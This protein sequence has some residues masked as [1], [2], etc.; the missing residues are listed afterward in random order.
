MGICG[1]GR[2]KE[3]D[4]VWHRGSFSGHNSFS[5][6]DNLDKNAGDDDVLDASKMAEMQNQVRTQRK[7]LTVQ[8]NLVGLPKVQSPEEMAAALKQLEAEPQ[9]A[10][11]N[12][13]GFQDCHY[14]ALSKK[15]YVPY[16]DKVNQDSL[17]C[18]ERVTHNVKGLDMHFFG[19]LDG[20]GHHGRDVSQFVTAE[21]PG[22]LEREL[23]KYTQVQELTNQVITEVLTNAVDKV[24]AKLLQ[25]KIPLQ[26]SGTTFCGSLIFNNTIY[27][28]NVG[29]SQG[30][31]LAQGVGNQDYT[32]YD[33]NYLHN[34]DH[35]EEKKRIQQM[36]GV[37]SQIPG[38]A[39]EE[40]GPFRIWLPDMTGPGLAMARSL[41]DTIAH[42][43]GA[44]HL[45]SIDIRKV[46]ATCKYV[47]WASDG[48]FEFL[49]TDDVAK[50]ILNNKGDL[51]AIAKTVVKQSVKMWRKYD[52]VVDDITVVLLQL[53]EMK[54]DSETEQTE[55]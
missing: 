54:E 35:P 43:I 15:G 24:H 48:V 31:V 3:D 42:K 33:L 50:I 17:I 11:A 12:S 8:G 49:S 40:A 51:K 34:P 46:D 18:L 14:V 38:L 1:S 26:H 28:A 30:F 39:P 53:P 19:V 29:D 55:I 52:Q 6:N 21:F 25:T 47:L 44:I 13:Q 2:K 7:R 41:G 32:I 20:H 45:P 37:V 10:G 36:G 27:T 22:F 9:S 16:D 5:G 4:E 23:S